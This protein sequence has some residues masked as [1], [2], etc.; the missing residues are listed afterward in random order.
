MAT[1]LAG[2]ADGSDDSSGLAKNDETSHAEIVDA[3]ESIS[4]E[5]G[6]SS[7]VHAESQ[8]PFDQ[9]DEEQ[10]GETRRSNRCIKMTEKAKARKAEELTKKFASGRSELVEVLSDTMKLLAATSPDYEE[11]SFRKT[12]ISARF[13]SLEGI[14][15]TLVSILAEHFHKDVGK[16]LEDLRD[17]TVKT[18]SKIVSALAERR[19]EDNVSHV[20]LPHSSASHMSRTSRASTTAS[21]RAAAE[22]AALQA[23]L[24]AQRLE[25]ERKDEL[26]LLELEENTRRME[27]DTRRMEADR[28][29]NQLRRQLD[30]DRL[31]AKLRAEEA[32]L[33]VYDEKTNTS[34]VLTSRSVQP[35]KSS[36][37]P[38]VQS[39][40]FSKHS[41][42]K[43][44]NEHE[45]LNPK[46]PVFQPST[47]SP[48]S[49]VDA[50]ARTMALS[51]LPI[52][53]HPI[54]TGDPLQYP[55]WLSSFSTLIE[56]K[57]IPP[58]ES[59]HY[60]KRYL[61]GPAKEAVSGFFL[62]RSEDAFLEAKK[63]LEK[64]FGSSFTVSEAFRSKLESW[65]RIGNRDGKSLRNLSDFLQQCLIATGE[66]TDLKIL[67]DI[68]E[69]KKIANKLP[70]WIVHRWNRLMAKK[71]REMGHYPS[72]RNFVDFVAEESEIINDPILSCESSSPARHHKDQGLPADTK[73]KR[74]AYKQT[75]MTLAT[76][77]EQLQAVPPKPGCLFCSRRNHTTSDCQDFAKESMQDKREFVKKER[78]CFGCLTK[79]HMSK[80][81][82]SRNE[83]KKCSRKHPTSLHD[84]SLCQLANAR[85]ARLADPSSDKEQEGTH[86]K[87]SNNGT[88]GK[89]S[90]NTGNPLT[91]M[92]V[93]VYISSQEN[94][95]REILVYALLDTMSDTTF[96]LDSVGEDL[97]T[98]SQSVVLRLTT[99]T[100]VSAAVPS[101]RFSNLT[102]RGYRSSEKIPLPATFSRDHIPLDEAHIP[103][104]DTASQWPH[105]DQIADFLVPKQDCPVGL[106]IGY[107]CS[108]ALAPRNCVTGKDNQ[109]FG[110]QTDLGWSIVGGSK[111]PP[112]EAFD[113]IGL[114]HRVLAVQ[115][116]AQVEHIENYDVRY[117]CKTQV[118]E[119]TASDFLLMME[120]DFQGEDTKQM[121]QDDMT[122]LQIVKEGIHQREDGYYEMPLPFRNGEPN[123]PNNR[124]AALHR[125]MGLKKQFVKRPRYQEHYTAFMREILQRGDAEKVPPDEVTSSNAWYIPHHGVYHPKKPNKVRVVFD[126]SARYQEKCL[127]DHLLQGPDLINPLVGVLCRFREGP[128]AFTCDVEKMYHQFRVKK[129]H[130]DYLRF[131]WWEHGDLSKTPVDFRMKVHLFGATS[132]PGCANFGLKQIASDYENTGP[133]AAEFLKKNF[134]VDDGLKGESTVEETVDLIKKAVQICD[135]GNLRLHKIVCN[136]PEVLE[137]LPASECA[138]STQTS[139]NVD[140]DSQ[141][142]R[143]LGLQWCIESDSF[144]FKLTLKDTPLT[145]RGVL[146]TV[147]SV[148]DPLGLIAPLILTGKQILQQMCQQKMHWDDPVPEELR[149]LWE[150]WREELVRLGQ[151]KIP[152]CF[153]PSDFGAV[154]R[155]EL[156]HFSDASLVGYGQCSYV[157][158]QDENG[159]IH[160]SLAMAKARV[161]PLKATTVP[162]LELQAATA[163]TKIAK[164]LEMELDYPEIT[165]H[166]WTDSKV[167]LGYIRNESKRFHMYVANRVQQILQRSRSEQWNYVA[168]EE[169][170]ADHASR[171]LTAN[172][173]VSSNWLTGPAFL[174]ERDIT[175]EQV[176]VQISPE[177]VEVKSAT[178]RMTHK[179][180]L[181]PTDEP[182]LTSF[183]ERTGRFSS[184][185]KLIRAVSVLVNCSLK[186]H[187]KNLSK[188]ETQKIA[189]R[190]LIRA[191]QKETFE[192]PG[193]KGSSPKLKT[194]KDLD[195]FIDTEDLL[196]VGGRLK[197]ASMLYGVKH[198]I[199]LPKGNHMSRLVALHCHQKTAHQG[200]NLTINAIRSSGFWIVGCRSLVSSLINKCI[201]CIRYRGNPKGQK[202]ADLPK[203]RI[204]P[205]PPFTY[206]GLDC[207]GPF[208]IKEGRKE[209]KRYGLIVTCLAMRAIHIEVLEDMSTD[210]F[211][212]G[213]RCF[214][215]LRGKVRLIRCD[216]GSNFVGAKNELKDCLKELNSEHIASQLLKLECEFQFNPP[217]SSHMGGVWERQIRN[218]RNVLNGI[219]DQSGTQLN[220]ASLRTFLYETMAIVNSRPLTVENLESPDGPT[221]LTPNHLLTMKSDVVMPPPGN[222]VKEDLYLRKRWRRVQFLTN[223]FWSRWKKEYL[224]S[225]QVRNTWQK[226]QRNIDVGD[227]VILQDEGPR[228]V[229]K[230]ARVVETFRSEDG[231]VRKVKLLMST[232]ELDKHGRP[233]QKRTFLDR[234]VHK[235]VVL[236]PCAN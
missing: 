13:N 90:T 110:V 145:R 169:N 91:S 144:C 94:P 34:S 95:G 79:G 221:P 182:I 97:E 148:Y 150:K 219:L 3:D 50:L 60:L 77:A 191:I 45:V 222:F 82:P 98:F 122:F 42:D 167:V 68:R 24:E 105:L 86:R 17:I 112:T 9:K 168:T 217:S 96:V 199:I 89:V 113:S 231:L 99:M 41:S 179:T 165:H 197:R 70:D 101:R 80:R 53:E 51:R 209:Q 1:S 158:L 83:C 224:H 177:D 196:R 126:C 56:C 59:I 103:T 131:L 139:L 16:S 62:L 15:E 43:G 78:L 107:N 40:T 138:S 47:Q 102:V 67:N 81:C 88:C 159:R 44:I 162:R 220:T 183:E 212:I 52:P 58:A 106:L 218:V 73:V 155:V 166:Y 111:A 208:L 46:A 137:K 149:P 201:R 230:T 2:K 23:K 38:A 7:S 198:P 207:F 154:T 54:F 153:Q 203:E 74:P 227:I 142:E 185:T 66:I 11:L 188:L 28:K 204:E 202:M 205:S 215:A 228:S 108:R 193:R 176:D 206:C 116:P 128:I 192:D 173:I 229:W 146:A 143:T 71:K 156:H 132:S 225:L 180:N 160:C 233:L 226:P 61:G 127:N 5:S 120:K 31:S 36:K 234:P 39:E 135:K 114:T 100:D 170:S 85:S 235:L 26:E 223:L 27:A 6:A 109:P 125:A 213:L 72:F 184:Y 140:H 48:E 21:K 172:E 161:V 133:K 18:I 123:L 20:S 195:P 130:Q 236:L 14:A 136:S 49:L 37:R 163:S 157:R 35:A 4:T 92:V 63:V 84:E 174:W 171:G 152:R 32:K 10:A 29:M 189:E 104:P 216:Q 76:N 121:S 187:G 69:I 93:P 210:S 232:A 186:R 147:A 33:R 118:K 115:T 141:I 181:S 55:D 64:R 12:D 129:S 75:R 87:A 164:I 124:Q 200:R 117:V 151:I 8:I 30:E 22:A 119:A 194:L 19:S 57:G 134:Y 25:N 190:N 211:L 214:I 178:A 65:P 175:P